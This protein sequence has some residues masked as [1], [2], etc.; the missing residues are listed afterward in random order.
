MKLSKSFKLQEF[1]ISDKHPELIEKVHVPRAVKWNL[2]KLCRI[3][4]QN[5]RDAVDKPIHITSGY[6]TEALNFAL[7]G[8]KASQ[9][10]FG[11]GCDYVILKED[12]SVDTEAMDHCIAFAKN[13]LHFA[14]GQHIIYKN[15][16][17]SIRHIHIS[18][19]DNRHYSQFFEKVV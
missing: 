15:G 18:L 4:L 10:L 12:G 7:G 8:A 13:S 9:H 19:P 5:L 6:R 1:L 14:I 17:G 16:D 11:E 2:Q 3:L